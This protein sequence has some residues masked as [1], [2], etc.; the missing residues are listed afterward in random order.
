MPA[1]QLIAPILLAGAIFIAQQQGMSLGVL[2][3]GLQFLHSPVYWVWQGPGALMEK[4]ALLWQGKQSVLLENSRLRQDN[5]NL[6]AKIQVLRFLELENQ[7]LR[8]LLNVGE[9]PQTHF[10]A[11]RVLR[12]DLDPFRQQVLVNKGKKEGISVGQPVVDAGG[13]VGVVLEV[14]ENTSR[15]LLLTDPHFAVSVQSLKSGERAIA[16]GNGG[17]GELRLNYVPRTA[18]FVEGET[19]VTSGLGGRFPAGVP[20][21]VITSIQ[22]DINARF[23]LIS[24]RPTAELQKLRHVLFL[25]EKSTPQGE[26]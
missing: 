14:A 6:Q 25:Q 11:A 8:T 24:V 16:T 9:D 17:G 20:V 15:M 7:G 19:L 22:H 12:L 5:L 13:L 1:W 21:G 26:G 23:A 18:P 4:A 2:H 3:R 10:V